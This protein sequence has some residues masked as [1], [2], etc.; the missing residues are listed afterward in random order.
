MP[1]LYCIVS[2]EYQKKKS[3]NKGQLIN[4][5]GLYNKFV[6]NACY[7]C[8]VWNIGNFEYSLEVE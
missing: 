5:K 2:L 6:K 4:R 1:I 3:Y 7:T 8:G